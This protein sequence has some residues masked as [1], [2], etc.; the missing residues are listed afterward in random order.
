MKKMSNNARVFTREG[1]TAEILKEVIDSIPL[2]TKI[3]VVGGAARN[4]VYYD[5]F[6]KSLPQRDYDLLLVGNLEKFVDNLRK[7]H[8]FI[9]GRIRRKNQVVLKKKMISNPKSI[10]DFM[11]LDIHQSCE[12][13]ILNNLKSNSAF[14]INGFAIPLQEYLSLDIKKSL[15]ALPGAINDLKKHRLSL[16][17]SGYKGHPGNLFACLRFMSAG[18]SY[19]DKKSID[20]LLRQLPKLEKWRFERNVKKVFGYVG[21]EKNARKLVK[22]LGVNVDIFDFQKLKEFAAEKYQ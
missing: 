17:I 4:A 19:P 9:Y 3:Y 18:F 21:G 2:K 1:K 5:F 8:K 7:K 6:K 11:A 12:S 13:N 15:V 16:N 22:Q 10:V 14:T 20:L